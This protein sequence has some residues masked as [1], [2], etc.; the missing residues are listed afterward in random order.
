MLFTKKFAL[1]KI[2]CEEVM[3]EVKRDNELLRE[4]V[5]ELEGEI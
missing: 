3:E 4:R 5:R 2:E 1:E